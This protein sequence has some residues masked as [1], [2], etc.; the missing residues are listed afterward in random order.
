MQISAPG[1]QERAMTQRPVEEERRETLSSGKQRKPC[2]GWLCGKTRFEA[3]TST[4]G[5]SPKFYKDTCK[6]SVLLW[7]MTAPLEDRPHTFTHIISDDPHH[8]PLGWSHIIGQRGKLRLL[9]PKAG[10]RQ[11]LFPQCS[12]LHITCMEARDGTGRK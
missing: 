8:R 12:L 5:L 11:W 3:S 10:R 9:C 4:Q 2:L 1:L 6:R 7:A